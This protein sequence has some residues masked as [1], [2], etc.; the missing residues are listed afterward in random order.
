MHSQLLCCLMTVTPTLV[1]GFTKTA[2]S[3]NDLLE[4]RYANAKIDTNM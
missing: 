4:S 2:P 3:N 1:F